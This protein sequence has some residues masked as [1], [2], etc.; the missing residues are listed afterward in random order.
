MSIVAGGAVVA[1]SDPREEFD[2][3]LLKA[4]AIVRACGKVAREAGEGNGGGGSGAG[5]ANGCRQ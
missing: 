5:A 3:M 4:T 2:E 1:M